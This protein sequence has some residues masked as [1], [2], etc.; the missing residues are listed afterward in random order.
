MVD[1]LVKKN[2]GE[3]EKFDRDKLRDSLL[4][5]SAS[6]LITDDVIKK[7]EKKLRPGMTTAQIYRIAFSLIHKK[8]KRTAYRYSLRRSILTLGPTGFPFEKFVARIFTL[9]GFTTMTGVVLKGKCVEHEVDVLAYNEN[10]V[11]VMEVKFHNSIGIKTDTKVALYVKARFDDLQNNKIRLTTEDSRLPTR[12]ILITNTKFTNNAEKYGRCANLGMI[13]WDYPQN[14][15]LYDLIDETGIHPLTAL[16]S[17]SSSN[18]E[19]L[20]NKGY[21]CC[22]QLSYAALKDIGLSQSKIS[23]VQKE[24]T[25]ICEKP[26]N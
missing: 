25:L 6:L 19:E 18:K 9:K 2:N 24:I 12:G 22:D 10:E 26:K 15:N 1:I 5:A 20:I 3:L 7:V 16:T 4:R 11:A 17:L 14:G 8:E 23:K 21:I 13:S